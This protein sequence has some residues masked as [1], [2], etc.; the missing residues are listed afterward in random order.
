[1]EIK[2]VDI[3]EL[4]PYKDNPRKNKDSIKYVAESIKKFGFKVPIVVDQNYEIIAGHTRLE[5]SKSLHLKEVPII[6]ANDLTKEQVKAFRLADNKV[7]E[8]AKWDFDKLSKELE[9]IDKEEAE[10]LG[11]IN[12]GEEIDWSSIEE[13]TEDNYQEPDHIIVE[14]PYCHHEDRREKFKKSKVKIDEN[15]S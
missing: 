7:S 2:Y 15:I 11:F 10:L 5:A 8:L 6:I 14:C 3:K 1:M 4:K 13:I 9:N 12:H